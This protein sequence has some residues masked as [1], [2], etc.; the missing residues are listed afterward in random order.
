MGNCVFR[1]SGELNRSADT[2]KVMTANGG[3]MELFPPVT[4]ECITSEFPGH[5]IYKTRHHN[6]NEELFPQSD[7]PL[8]HT[9]ELRLGQ[10]YYLLPVN[11]PRTAAKDVECQSGG[12]S[13][14]R[15]CATPYRMSL[16]SGQ[17]QRGGH[18]KRWS[19][20][21]GCGLEMTSTTPRCNRSGVWKVKLVISPEQ[22]S[23][24]LAQEST[25][26][27]LVESLR[28]VAKCGNGIAGS[29]SISAS[30]QWSISTAPN[31]FH[32]YASS[33]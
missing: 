8:L 22:L 21:E 2:I 10:S 30:D 14:R 13:V 24:I 9:D 5:A 6:D 7:H 26:E 15:H 12:V 32:D 25:T 3:V 27:E 1:G 16:D 4:A 20:S 28:T 29:A 17:Q 33:V 31:Q 18:Q 11:K 19:S 23:E